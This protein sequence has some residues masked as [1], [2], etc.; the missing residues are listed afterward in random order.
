MSVKGGTVSPKYID[1]QQDIFELF[2]TFAKDE[3]VLIGS[4]DD[5]RGILTRYDVFYFL[6]YHFEPFIIIGEIERALRLMFDSSIDNLDERVRETFEPR[7]DHDASYSVPNSIEYFNFEEYKRFITTNLDVLPAQVSNDKDFIL[8]LLEQVR[9]NRN[10]LFHF[11]SS[12]DEIDRESLDV[13]HS[14]F[15]GLIE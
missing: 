5:L 8:K 1:I 11:R 2:E 6:K 7:T 10:A 12:A 14:Y 9:I 15:T 4:R 3:Y 13:A